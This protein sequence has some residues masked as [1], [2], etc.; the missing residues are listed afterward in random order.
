MNVCLI[1][2]G[3]VKL[4]CKCMVTGGVNLS[5]IWSK[6]YLYDHFNQRLHIHQTCYFT[7][8][9][10]F[11]CP[12]CSINHHHSLLKQ[13][14]TVSQIVFCPVVLS[15]VRATT[16]SGY[17]ISCNVIGPHGNQNIDLTAKGL[18]STQKYRSKERYGQTRT[19]SLFKCFL[20]WEKIGD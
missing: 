10:I 9:L 18:S 20:G 15:S 2:A 19:Q 11:H 1:F 17:V 16:R 7:Q 4:L 3:I 6:N 5:K 12:V 13:S 14:S 8:V